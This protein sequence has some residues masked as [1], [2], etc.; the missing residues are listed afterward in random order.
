MGKDLKNQYFAGLILFNIAF[1]FGE[2]TQYRIIL[3]LLIDI[4]SVFLLNDQEK[5]NLRKINYGII[6]H[7]GI[8][9]FTFTWFMRFLALTSA[10]C[11]I[12]LAAFIHILKPD[13]LKTGVL[14]AA[15]IYYFCWINWM[16]DSTEPLDKRIINCFRKK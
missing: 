11:F 8:S 4:C 15:A 9:R 5:R 10:S 3:L 12:L 13:F 16:V 7:S 14:F 6:F 2:I 1:L